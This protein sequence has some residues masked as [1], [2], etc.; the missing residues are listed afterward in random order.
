MIY[1][2]RKNTLSAIKKMSMFEEKL[3]GLYR[4][5]NI[6]VRD[7]LGRRN[8]L[9][10]Q[11]QELFFYEEILKNGFEASCSGKTGEP[12]IVIESIGKEVECKL[13]SGSKSSWPL[14]CDYS[15]LER[16]GGLD[17]L[18]VLCNKSFDKF[19][20]LLF[21]NLTIDDFYF[22]APGSRQKS[23]MNKSS[24]MDKCS[25]LMGNVENKSDVYV[26]KYT[27]DLETHMRISGE[28]LK[29][30]DNRIKDSRTRLQKKK[31]SGVLAREKL[32][33][34]KKER[35][36]KEKI[37]YWENN[38]SHYSISLESL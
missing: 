20:V 12:D 25:V 35:K 27:D 33:I 31:I 9:M 6:D 7:N 4:S 1:L 18:Y 11:T 23:R 32:R 22:P 26:K 15:T 30:L 34:L 2:T 29:T 24:A 13:T 28:R 14:Q 16:K 10:S 37:T 21:A 5:Y 3:C 36:I 38:D 8:M 17:F 19:A